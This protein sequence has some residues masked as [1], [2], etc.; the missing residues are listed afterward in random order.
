MK[1]ILSFLF[2]FVL[3]GVT[4]CKKKETTSLKVTVYDSDLNTGVPNWKVYFYEIN[5]KF[6]GP[7]DGLITL[8]KTGLTDA[9]GKID[10]GDIETY[11]KNNKYQYFVTSKN[12]LSGK[13]MLDNKEVV[14]GTVND[15]IL[16]VHE[17]AK[18]Y[19]DITP[20]MPGFGYV[21]TL[22]FDL[23]GKNHNWHFYTTNNDLY[24]HNHPVF[25]VF[26]DTYYFNINKF[27]SGVYT[28]IRDTVSYDKFGTYHY[29]I[30]W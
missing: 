3:I 17:W 11:R 16:E 29:T 7:S 19:I 28:N 13:P 25:D 20:T 26:A 1:R 15:I 12:D 5:H 23:M 14:E 27:K 10:F 18:L 24:L 2:I 21:D 30:N 8:V 9:D 22:S 4:A 6:M